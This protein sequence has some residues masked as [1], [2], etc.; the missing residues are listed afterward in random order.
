LREA[1]FAGDRRR[2][3]DLLAGRPALACTADEDGDAPLHWAVRAAA[4]HDADDWRV[5]VTCLLEAGADCTA[6][7][8]QGL[9]PLDLAAQVPY[10]PA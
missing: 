9:T 4:R 1:V 5:I 3:K 7:N 10:D 6:R 8:R 2:V